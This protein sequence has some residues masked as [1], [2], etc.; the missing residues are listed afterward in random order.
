MTG[1]TVKSPSYR[2]FGSGRTRFNLGK[3]VFAKPFQVNVEFL[4]APLSKEQIVS[5][6]S[7]LSNPHVVV[8]YIGCNGLRSAG[9]QF[10]QDFLISPILMNHSEVTFWL[11]DLTAWGA[12][13]KQQCSVLNYNSACEVIENMCHRQVKCIRSADIFDRMQ[14]MAETDLVEYFHRALSKSFISSQSKPFQDS[15]ILTGDIFSWHCPVA[16]HWYNHDSSKTYSVFQ[17]LEG[18]LIVE[19]ILAQNL[20]NNNFD[21]QVIFVLPNDE[22]KY[23]MDSQN[24]F[25]EDV[26]F[27]VSKQ[28]EVLGI[29][30]VRLQVSFLPFTYGL[31]LQDRPYNAPG[32]V[33]KSRDL[34]GKDIIG[35][36]KKHENKPKLEALYASAVG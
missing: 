23:Y 22:I 8:W 9:V 28:C 3:K 27:L 6:I 32:K 26:K 34:S 4:D 31:I 12:F 10:Y 13:K 24:S 18:C 21:V 19:K 25:Q 36:M 35:N 20:L 33:L 14:K 17:Y 11:V 5:Y 29:N 15:N 1:I 30:N 2:S 16:S 7:N